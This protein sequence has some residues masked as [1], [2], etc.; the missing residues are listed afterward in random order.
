MSTTLILA[1]L[2]CLAL[3]AVLGFLLTRTLH[4]QAQQRKELEDQLEKTRDELKE[5]Q[6]AVTTHFLDTSARVNNLTESYRSLHE[7][8]A[9]GAMHLANPEISRQLIE[10][11]YGKLSPKP[12]SHADTTKEPIAE[13]PEPPKD[14]A[15]DSGVLRED[16]GLKDEHHGPAGYPGPA[17]VDFHDDDSDQDPTMKTG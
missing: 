4:P 15:P 14:Y 17:A 9:S 10:A 2:F 11:G 5:Y 1:C 7:H 13:A 8:L 12:G 3:G 6:Q 16:Y